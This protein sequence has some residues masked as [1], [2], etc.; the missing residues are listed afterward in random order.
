MEIFLVNKK[1]FP[2]GRSLAKKTIFFWEVEV[3]LGKDKGFAKQGRFNQ[4]NIEV[5]QI[6]KCLVRREKCFAKG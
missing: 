5:L 2:I 6:G 3:K 1:V 4:E